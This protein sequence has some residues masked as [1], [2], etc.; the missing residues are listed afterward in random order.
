MATK[1][2]IVDDAGFICE[3]LKSICEAIGL[4]VLGEANNGEDGLS[5]CIQMKPDLVFMDLVMPKMNGSDAIFKIRERNLPVK[6]IA[7][8]TLEESQ[9]PLNGMKIPFNA[10]LAKPFTKDSVKKAVQEALRG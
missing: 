4:N 8:S 2:V 6:V 1:V 3:I 10:F 7:C 9:A 5:L